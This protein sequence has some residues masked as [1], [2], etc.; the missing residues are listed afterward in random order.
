[1]FGTATLELHDFDGDE[2]ESV[3]SDAD[4]GVDEARKAQL[5]SGLGQ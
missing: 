4:E 1:M 2:D 5:N 3:A